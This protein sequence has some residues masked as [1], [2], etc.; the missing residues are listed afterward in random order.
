MSIKRAIVN[1]ERDSALGNLL[2]RGAESLAGSGE[3]DF[4][5]VYRRSAELSGRSSSVA[6]MEHHRGLSARHA[7]PL[8]AAAAAALI[9]G[10]VLQR[11]SASGF[12]RDGTLYSRE[13]SQL[14]GSVAGYRAA[15]AFS[16]SFLPVVGGE[17]STAVSVQESELTNFV[18]D[19]WN[20]EN[21]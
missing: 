13:I 15:P 17:G 12:M 21:G 9:F 20:R 5:A 4:E 11:G 8:L 18:G 6:R 19:L 14:A 16:A 7:L 2:L 1:D 10:L 3:P